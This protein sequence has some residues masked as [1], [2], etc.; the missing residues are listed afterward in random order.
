MSDD[1]MREIPIRIAGELQN[2]GDPIARDFEIEEYSI[3]SQRT[4]TL[5]PHPAAP[6]RGHPPAEGSRNAPIGAGKPGGP[7]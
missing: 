4:G 3:A 5:P 2:E 6:L 7:A 1:C